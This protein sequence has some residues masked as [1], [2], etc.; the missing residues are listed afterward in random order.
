MENDV[1]Q[2]VAKVVEYLDV[3]EDF[4]AE[5]APIL[6]QEMLTWGLITYTIDTVV[7]LFVLVLCIIATKWAWKNNVEMFKGKSLYDQHPGWVLTMVC[8]VVFGAASFFIAIGSLQTI[9]QILFAPR[10]YLME[11]AASLIN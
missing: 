5:Q 11:R 8:T 7:S 4:V 3:T 1:D 2:L 10:V 9:A 6:I